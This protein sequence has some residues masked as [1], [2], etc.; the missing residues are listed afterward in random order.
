[1][2]KKLNIILAAIISAVVSCVIIIPNENTQVFSLKF[3][4]IILLSFIL[5]LLAVLLFII[6]IFVIFSFTFRKESYEDIPKFRKK[7]FNK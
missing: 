6:F 3:F 2:L 4:L 1:M 5:S 7:I